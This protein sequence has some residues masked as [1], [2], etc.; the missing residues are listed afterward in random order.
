[1]SDSMKTRPKARAVVKYE[2]AQPPATRSL[3]VIGI[4]QLA[5]GAIRRV[6][7]P[8]RRF[9]R[10]SARVAMHSVIAVTVIAIVAFAGLFVALSNGPISMS[11]LVPPIE[12]A[13]N[14][15]LSG[16][17]FD[18][19]DAV[20]RKAD[21]GYGIEFRL[22]DVR[23]VDNAEGPVVEAPLA[24]AGLSL[25][26]LLAGRLA[27]GDVDLI[28]PS[29]FLNYSE[30]RG[31]TVTPGDPR[32]AK[33]DL[34]NV[35]PPQQQP[36]AQGWRPNLQTGPAPERS[37]A[38]ARPAAPPTSLSLTKALNGVFNAVRRGETAY[39][40]RFG[41]R[42]ATVVF[43]RGEEV[44]RWEVPYAAIDLEHERRNSAVV[45]EVAVRSQ[46]GEWQ[47]KFR[48]GQNRRN[49]ELGLAI[50]VDDVNPR[51]IAAEFPTFKPLKHF[52][53]PVSVSADL[54]LTGEGDIIKADMRADLQNGRFF[55][56]GAEKYPVTIDRGAFRLTYSREEGRIELL[57]SEI[58]W[59]DSRIKLAGQMQRQESTGLWQFQ[60]GTTE[61]ALGALEFGLP[62]IPV[63]QMVTQGDYDPRTK[64]LNLDR[65]FLQAADA[66]VTL[67]G[68]IKQGERSPAIKI[69]GSIS[70]MPA[71]F[72][73]LIW[74]KFVAFG[75]RDWIGNHIPSGRIAGGSIKVDIPADLLATLPEGGH[76][77]ASAVDC[78]LE[79]ENLH[80]RFWGELPPIHTA[81]ATASITGHRFFFS[82]PDGV[83]SLPSG[84]RLTLTN[85]E[86]IIGDL[87]P[88][89][90]SAEIHFKT[91]SNAKAAF[92]FLDHEPLHYIR[93]LRIK[94]PNVEASLATTFSLALPLLR[95]VKFSDLKMNGRANLQD[96]RATDLPGGIGIQGG[97]AEFDISETAVEARGDVKMNG[98][99]VKIGWQ[100]I[101]DAAPDLQPPLR[102]R[103][104]IDDNARE[105]MGLDINHVLRGPVPAELTLNL[106]KDAPPIVRFE[107]NLSDSDIIM[108]S[109]GWRK[110]PGQR[111]LLTTDIETAED[112]STFLRNFSLAGDDLALRGEIALNDKRKPIAFRFP[113]VALNPQT[114]LE[115]SG[116]LN[117]QNIWKVRASGSGYD[118]R[119]FF[120]SLFSAGKVAE[121]QPQLPKNTPGLDAKIDIE[122]VTGFFD[123]TVQKVT[124]EARRRND[125]LVFLDMHG[126][127]NGRDPIATRLDSKSGEPRTLLAETTDGGAAFRLVGFYPSARG[128][129]ISLKVN[130]D[131]SGPAEKV[132]ILYARNFT[133]AGDQVV[134]EVLSGPKDQRAARTR[135]Q[136]A[137]QYSQ[138]QFDNMRVPFSVGSGQ[139]VLH[140]A[141]INGPMLGASLRGNIDF[142]RERI[143]V[144]G[145]YVPLFGLNGAIGAV[146]IL[147][148][149]LVSR[150]GEGL[151]GITFAVQGAT[152]NP[153]VLVNPMSMVAPG[154]LR[155][156][157]EFDQNAPQIIPPDK[158][159]PE[160]SGARSSSAPPAT[161]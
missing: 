85:G 99:P 24:S 6:P 96:V 114:Q 102:V 87:R 12:K 113:T 125:R 106:R 35:A 17:R 30:E 90:P 16:F 28:G 161:R 25:Q 38:P 135:Q 98:V 11:F 22:A 83:V 120:R 127:L 88:N 117:A 51:M 74:P 129:E 81:K 4:G 156:L 53:M 89:V 153:D 115:A 110:P 92:E 151:F 19:G 1:M 121:D 32:E 44:T 150:H 49:G 104:V 52:N 140:D 70:P 47:V 68:A 93:A 107:A 43:D 159:P 146:P 119:L 84:N 82:V 5:S 55:A 71:A 157:F 54:D 29:L 122:N 37:A 118:G 108:A 155:Q 23:L 111:A 66:Q 77:P 109:A 94:T 97:T 10:G 131:G 142:K 130:L 80:I 33:G 60:F 62:A 86:F 112:G 2:H 145:T 57:P 36:N 154:F 15:G 26:A 56:P 100:R 69:D 149:L 50:S 148:D 20:L 101:Y 152:S 58:R 8:V 18:V 39:L 95:E 78:R 73:K 34:G 132:G 9:T 31:L 76:M 59:D 128:G 27:P 63:D 158:R 7:A 124:I 141:I 116:E 136:P 42:D 91:Q 137:Q 105:E 143:A 75:A 40:S 160:R 64:A 41:I 67:S 126:R 134:G 45:G 139:F 79:V 3:A 144:S 138:L 147:G 21:S 48:A 61:M 123:T 103:A 14:A 65:F 13:V 72:F 133:I 46:S